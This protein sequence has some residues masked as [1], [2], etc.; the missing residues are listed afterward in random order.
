ML[1]HYGMLLATIGFALIGGAAMADDWT[2]VQLRGQ[3]MQFV[4]K[5]WQPVQR[6]D[7]V[8][9]ETMVR[10][11]N[12]GHADFVR[13]EETVS[14]DP[15]TEITIHD[16]PTG[17][18]KPYTTVS[19]Y[20]G[21]VSVEAEVQHV[22]HFSVETPYLAAVVKGTKFTVVSS[23]AGSRVSVERGHVQ[24]TDFAHHTATLI[25]AGQSASI[26]ASGPSSA[27]LVVSGAGVLPPVTG[28]AG[29]AAVGLLPGVGSTVTSTVGLVGSTLDTT[30]GA[31][32]STVDTTVGFVG[33]TVGSVGSTVETTVGTVT[34]TVSD[35]TS[36]VDG[37][38]GGVVGGVLGG[39]SDNGT[40]NDGQSGTGQQHNNGNGGLVGSLL[41]HLL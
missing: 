22:Q 18:G 28:G 1:R 25:S 19:Q 26:G 5:S 33:S 17:N 30:V 20:F 12:N 14:L 3:V 7:V 16:K 6:G 2:A 4:D 36:T 41:H 9:D 24:V 27:G 35:V 8:A 13:G 40:G 38:V 10:T 11:S 29:T 34:S 31:V 37:V 15:N 21:T 32:G 23:H 39:H